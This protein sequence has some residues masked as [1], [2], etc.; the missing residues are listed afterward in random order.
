MVLSTAAG[1]WSNGQLKTNGATLTTRSKRAHASGRSTKHT[2]TIERS[3]DYAKRVKGFLKELPTG[4]EAL[5][6][7]FKLQQ[8]G[9]SRNVTTTK[10]YY[11]L[12]DWFRKQ[13]SSS[14][15]VFTQELALRKVGKRDDAETQRRI[16]ELIEQDLRNFYLKVPGAKL[17]EYMDS[18]EGRDLVGFVKQLMPKEKWPEL[19]GSWTKAL[20]ALSPEDL[21]EA[22]G[23]VPIA[24]WKGAPLT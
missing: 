23:Y 17:Y 22:G 16:L 5:L 7:G 19:P 1:S 14:P 18:L 4:G 11:D 15:A 12:V 21:C 20:S 3:G 8:D 13:S 2:R 10:P 6:A 24:A 9:V